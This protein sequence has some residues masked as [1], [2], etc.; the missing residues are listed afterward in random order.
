LFV[1]PAGSGKRIAARAFAAALLGDDSALSDAHPDLVTVEREGASISVGQA[2][3]IARLAA[4]SPMEGDRKVLVLTD[5]H[6]V[7]EAAPALLKTIEEA[8]ASTVFVI[9][10]DTVTRDLVTVASRCARVDFSTLSNELIAETLIGEGIDDTRAQEA[11]AGSFGNLSR[12]RLLAGD[13]S[14]AARR[15]L[16]AGAQ[17]RL[18]G[19]G[20][21]A[22]SLV[23]EVIASLDLASEPLLRNHA[24]EEQA[25]RERAKQTG[26]SLGT[27]ALETRQKREVRRLRTDEVKAGLA[28]LAQ[29]IAKQL[30]DAQNATAA[31]AVHES[32]DAIRWATQALTFNPNEVLLLQGLFARL[33]A[34][35]TMRTSRAG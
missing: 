9:L 12:A 10:A 14:V 22:A 27:K 5:F 4:R 23:D 8:S 29:E 15:S 11:A 20:T 35:P 30:S 16:W 19:T 34:L 6:L 25:M 26:Q 1:G 32:L 21:T 24:V 13:D 33:S 17:A 28:T 2:R 31:N 18:D 3:E 7:E